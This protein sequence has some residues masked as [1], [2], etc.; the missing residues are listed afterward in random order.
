MH[1]VRQLAEAAV[2]SPIDALLAAEPGWSALGYAPSALSLASFR[3]KPYGIPFAIS[4]PVVYYNADLA[5]RAGATLE[6]RPSAWPGIIALGDRIRETGG[7]AQGIFFDYYLQTN[8]W[9]FHALVQSFGGRMMSEDDRTIA[10]GGREGFEALR[11]LRDIGRAGMVDQ[12]DAQSQQAFANGG[13]G[14]LVQSGARLGGIT[15]TV[16]GRFR[17]AVGRLPVQAPSGR[18]PAGGM[19]AV[20]QTA[21]PARRAAGWEFVKFV[22]GPVGQ[23][24]MVRNTGYVPSNIIPVQDPGMLGEFYRQNPNYMTLGE[25]M[26]VVAAFYSFPG[27]NS[28]RI[29]VVL[30]EH[31]RT[32]VTGQ[33]E[34]EAALA[35]MVRDVQALL[36]P[37]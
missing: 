26:P 12:T 7:G 23:T 16:D 13:L 22:T 10:F 18:L 6:P 14:I 36:P 28:L 9:T 24:L 11:V 37:A 17:V 30:R 15:R 32:V 20:L 35:D 3:G 29:P 33:R 4:A 2:V 27:P 19:A 31:L 5:A 1:Y 34:P 8:N 25:T 21:D